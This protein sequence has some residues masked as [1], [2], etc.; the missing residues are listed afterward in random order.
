MP[1]PAV[2]RRLAVLAVVCATLTVAAC[3]TPPR[4]VAP[5]TPPPTFVGVSVF[6]QDH[7]VMVREVSVVTQ[8]DAG[9][10]AGA[11]APLT[12]QVWN[13]TNKPISLISG[14]AGKAALVLVGMSATPTPTFDVVVPGDANIALNP[15]AGRY[16]QVACLPVAAPVGSSLSMTFRF[17]NG[18]TITTDVPVGAYGTAKPGPGGPPSG[19]ACS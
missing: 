16:L 13:N 2:A 18:A 17:S 14:T 8:G 4:P 9:F 3:G 1:R 15:Q 19:T 10:Q 7:S 6:S 12:M 5:P 11:S